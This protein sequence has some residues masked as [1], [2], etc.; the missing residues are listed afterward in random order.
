MYFHM[1]QVQVLRICNVILYDIFI[2]LLCHV[3]RP[4]PYDEVKRLESTDYCVLKDRE[5]FIL[6]FDLR[7]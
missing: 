6:H 2:A 1:R 5:S 7:G 4:S 3:S